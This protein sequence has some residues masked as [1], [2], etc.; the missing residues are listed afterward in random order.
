M[1]ILEYRFEKEEKNGLKKKRMEWVTNIEITRRNL[2]K[3][4]K[5]GGERWKIE[6]KGFNSQKNG[7]YN[8]SHMMITKFILKCCLDVFLTGRDIVYMVK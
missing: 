8:I 6:N 3:L 7:I 2:E 5:T 4:I 1:N